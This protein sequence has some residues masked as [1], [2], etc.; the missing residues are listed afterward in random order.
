MINMKLQ[1]L[2][3]IRETR[4]SLVLSLALLCG[5]QTVPSDLYNANQDENQQFQRRV[6]LIDL[7]EHAMLLLEEL[8]EPTQTLDPEPLLAA[9]DLLRI[10]SSQFP[11]LEGLHYVTLSGTLPLPG[12]KPLEVANVTIQAARGA[13][14]NHLKQAQWLDHNWSDLS[15]TIVELAPINVS[16]RGAVF[17]PGRV[18]INEPLKT[19]PQAEIR[20]HS[21]AF[22][23]GR[24]LAQA[25]RNAGGVRPDADLTAVFIKRDKHIQR[26][27][28][29]SLVDGSL[30]K[31]S[32]PLASGDEIII[33]TTGAEQFDLIRPT[34][35]T[36]PGMR[37]FMSNLTAPAL[38]NAQS[39]IGND[40]S[41]VPYG[42]SLIDVAI[43][44]NC[45][46]GTHMA[47]ASR[48][49][50]LVTRNH[51]GQGQLVIKR[52]INHL[53]SHSADPLSNPYV[54]PNDGVACYD[55]RFTNFRDVAR[56]L[57]ELIS[58]IILGRL[59]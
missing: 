15:L 9:G 29:S 21:G 35:I 3:F 37:V 51:G 43:S 48:S 59:L 31:P 57:G 16:I 27:D 11:E 13:L 49:I 36:P 1:S 33:A 24:S 58:P 42:V 47:N 17:N 34:P 22:T 54:M 56:G 14:L 4:A 38:S 7:S 50:I 53:L 46:G 32:I 44:A 19:K 10:S 23:N 6:E 52:K 8:A 28:I 41:R 39:S 12:L 40:A 26:L 5:C 20:Q 25:L 18:T 55:S 2:T 30:T 45:V